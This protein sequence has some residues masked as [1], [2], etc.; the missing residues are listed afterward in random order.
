MLPLTTHHTRFTHTFVHTH[1]HTTLHHNDAIWVGGWRLLGGESMSSAA[2]VI[3]GVWQLAYHQRTH[4][5][6]A[7]AVSWRSS[8]ASAAKK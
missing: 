5:Q 6:L 1:T 4:L 3:G 7:L 2:C 8:S